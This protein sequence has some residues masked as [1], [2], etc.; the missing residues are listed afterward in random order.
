MEISLHLNIVLDGIIL[1]W[2]IRKIGK[3][4]FWRIFMSDRMYPISSP[5][6]YSQIEDELEIYYKKSKCKSCP[7][8]DEENYYQPMCNECRKE[9]IS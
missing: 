1:K 6:F 5:Y 8:Y 3:I 9:K 4:W 2:F 7:F